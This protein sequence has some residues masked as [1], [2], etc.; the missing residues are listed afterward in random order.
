[1][2]EL[3][4]HT[5][6]LIHILETDEFKLVLWCRRSESEKGKKSVAWDPSTAG[7]FTAERDRLQ[8]PRVR[9]DTVSL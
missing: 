5:C 7:G 3:Q 2:P 6:M 4:A 1:M 9:D 8:S